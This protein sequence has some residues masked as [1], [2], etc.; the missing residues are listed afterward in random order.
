MQ[1]IG[2]VAYKTTLKQQLNGGE[3]I[4]LSVF[5]GNILFSCPVLGRMIFPSTG[6]ESKENNIV[7]PKQVSDLLSCPLLGRIILQALDTKTT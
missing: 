5:L 7:Q 2:V 3:L 6:H 1:I 4:H